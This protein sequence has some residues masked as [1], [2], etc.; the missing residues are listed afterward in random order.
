MD[1]G[2]GLAATREGLSETVVITSRKTTVTLDEKFVA[3]LVR[4]AVGAP[5]DS[6]V[7]FDCG[8]YEILRDVTVTWTVLSDETIPNASED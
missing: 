1:K 6:D 4:R 2:I 7:N 8:S 3:S 5:F